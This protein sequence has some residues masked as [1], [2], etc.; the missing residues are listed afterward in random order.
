MDIIGDLFE[1]KTMTKEHENF[2]NNLLTKIADA[3]QSQIFPDIKHISVKLEDP[4][5]KYD[6]VIKKTPDDKPLPDLDAYDI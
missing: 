4:K 3:K 6:V 5:P 1:N 2:L